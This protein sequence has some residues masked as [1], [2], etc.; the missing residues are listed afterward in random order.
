LKKVEM[1]QREN[2][3]NVIYGRPT[4]MPQV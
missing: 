1:E 4:E 2:F 3:Y